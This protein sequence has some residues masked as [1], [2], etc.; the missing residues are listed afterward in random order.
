MCHGMG[1]EVDTR[2]ILCLREVTQRARAGALR[3]GLLFTVWDSA[4]SFLAEVCFFFSFGRRFYFFLCL[5]PSAH[6][7]FDLLAKSNSHPA[8]ALC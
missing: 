4:S 6:S 1:A 8:L 7:P 3:P 2:A 5:V